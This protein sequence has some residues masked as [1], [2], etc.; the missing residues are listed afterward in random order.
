MNW[1]KKTNI[2]SFLRW[3]IKTSCFLNIFSACFRLCNASFEASRLMTWIQVGNGIF[4]IQSR[5]SAPDAEAKSKMALLG[6]PCYDWCARATYLGQWAG[7]PAYCCT[8]KTAQCRTDTSCNQIRIFTKNI[9]TSEVNQFIKLIFR[10]TWVDSWSD[11]STWFRRTGQSP[12]ESPAVWPATEV[13]HLH[14]HPHPHS[15]SLERWVLS[16]LKR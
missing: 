14:P 9:V 16:P 6:N 4:Y 5:I 12:A 15:P 1:R 10:L 3:L 7:R 2:A 13:E 11:K 8:G